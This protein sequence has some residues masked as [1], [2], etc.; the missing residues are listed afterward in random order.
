MRFLKWLLIVVLVLAGLVLVVP[1]LLPAEVEVTAETDV[2][3]SPEQVFHNVATYTDREKWDPWLETEPEAEVT[4]VP[5]ENYIG[6][7][8]SWNGEK[9]GKGRME[10]DSVIFGKYIGAKIWFG[11]FPDPYSVEWHLVPKDEGTHVTWTFFSKGK[12]PF[13]KLMNAMMKEGMEKSFAGGLEN[14]MEYIE[15]HPPVMY[16]LSEIMVDELDE[17]KT[18]VIME[19]GNMEDMEEMMSDGFDKLYGKIMEQGIEPAGSPF[20]YYFDWDEA[21]GSFKMYLG[22]PVD[23]PGEASNGLMPKVIPA[24]KAIVA[25]HYGSYDYFME[26][27]EALEKYAENNGLE[28]KGESFEI[29]H[30]TRMDSENPM[31]WRTLV[32]YPLK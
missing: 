21:S 13:G 7:T 24:M 32:G 2:S 4:I 9:I 27:Y 12:Y 5:A 8:Y 25:M 28:T 26:T 3:V 11:D 14:F 1:L 20:A 29:Y 22:V 6:S 18:M 17:V 15:S 30:S 16:R 19:E 10:V 31:D 23:E